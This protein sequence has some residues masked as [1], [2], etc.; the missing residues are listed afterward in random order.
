[1]PTATPDIT[2][3]E[4]A[5]AQVERTGFAVVEDVVD[6]DTLGTLTHAVER[7]AARAAVEGDKPGYAFR[8]LFN[9]VPETQA[10]LRDPH[11]AGLVRAVLGHGAFAVRGLLFEKVDGANWHVGWHQDQAIAINHKHGK[12][13][14]PGFGPASVKNG[15]PHTR[16]SAD[17]LEKMLAV[18]IHLDDCGGD[19]GPLRCAPGSHT[20]GRLDPADT[21]AALAHCTPST[22]TVRRGGVLLMRPL[23]LHAS[24]PAASP[25]HRRVIHI[26]F[27]GI[28]LPAPLDWHE[29]RPLRRPIAS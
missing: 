14:A 24:S 29:R 28:E 20:L 13:A 5:A 16:A 18:R 10:L 25:R 11:I 23:V 1:M 15:V 17:V 6:T 3:Y 7:E 4:S 8:D 12:D 19:N 9:A 22:C 21:R 27:A 2:L 26:E